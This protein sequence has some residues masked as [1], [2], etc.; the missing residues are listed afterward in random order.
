MQVFTIAE[1]ERNT[2]EKV[3]TLADGIDPALTVIMDYG[4][5]YEE[6]RLPVLDVEVW[7]GKN[8]VGDYKVLYSHYMKKVASRATIH[9]R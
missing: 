9:Y 8:I 7:I 4:S 6:G 1:S 2:M 5:R 3:K